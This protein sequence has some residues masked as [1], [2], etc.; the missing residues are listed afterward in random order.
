[1]SE[2]RWGRALRDRA[3]REKVP[4][5]VVGFDGQHLE[6]GAPGEGSITFIGVASPGL[7]DDIKR[8]LVEHTPLGNGIRRERAEKSATPHPDS[9]LGQA[10]SLISRAR[11]EGCSDTHCC[12]DSKV[13][14]VGTNGGCHCLTKHE[15]TLARRTVAR[16]ILRFFP[17]VVESLRWLNAA[18]HALMASQERAAELE[19]AADRYLSAEAALREKTA[20]PEGVRETQEARKALQHALATYREGKSR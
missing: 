9:L 19:R 20:S 1:M 18:N 7:L 12:F 15:E 5:A 8:V 13:G 3:K 4:L 11:Q 16:E 14:R 2:I 10:L 17:H 6:K